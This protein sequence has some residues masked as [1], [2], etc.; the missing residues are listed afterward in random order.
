MIE[1]AA[2]CADAI[3][4][5]AALLD[6]RAMRDLRELAESLA[7]ATLVEV[8]DT[9]ELDSALES[10]AP[11]IGVN[12]RDL[13]TFQVHLE[14][15]LTL[16]ERI[17][18]GTIMV[19]ESGIHSHDDIVRLQDAGYQAFLVGEHLMKSQDPS[20]AIRALRFGPPT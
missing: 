9:N 18:S 13:R 4:L 15:S 8:H 14:T 19:S 5:I 3:L 1:A 10:G 17:P 7:M 12:N 6:A 20:R 16:A 11:I 2:H